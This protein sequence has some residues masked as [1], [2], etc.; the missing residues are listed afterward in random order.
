VRP[1]WFGIV[2]G[3]AGLAL[4]AACAAGQETDTG[5]QT[6]D[7]LATGGL[8]SSLL[9]V[10]VVGE[11]YSAVQV[12]STV[13]T[14]ADGSTVSHR[15]H[16]FVARDADGRVHV[17]LRLANGRNGESDEVMVFVMDPV[18]HTLTT[19]LSGASNTPKTASVFKIAG[20][21]QS[22]TAVRKADPT[23]AGR[24]QPVITTENLGKQSL[25]GLEIS[26]ERTTTVVPAGRSGNSAPITKTH[27]VWTSGDLH[28]V[29][30]QKW[31]D[32]RYGE[33]RVELEKISREQPDQ[34]L[35]HAPP[36]YELRSA[37]QT[38]REFLDK[39]DAMQ[40]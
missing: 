2:I 31:K 19:W 33:R 5:S 30:K 14:L 28:L 8:V 10:P 38:L 27:E 40:N 25:Q 23:E 1:R 24:P 17:E 11:P 3:M 32:P 20:T 12:H 35:F 36:G 7:R 21:P 37:S 4:G 15:G 9:A 39:L 22:T 16:H 18:A 6:Q 13:R 26:G 34:G 29:V